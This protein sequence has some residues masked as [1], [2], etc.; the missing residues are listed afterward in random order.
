MRYR[1][2]NKHSVV[3]EI[4]CDKA[5]IRIGQTK[6]SGV[7]YRDVRDG[8]VC[9]RPFFEFYAIFEPINDSGHKG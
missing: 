4:V 2:R 3:V 5:I 7:V 8:D 9:T 1:N 6:W